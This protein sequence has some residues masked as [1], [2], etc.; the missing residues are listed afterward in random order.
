MSSLP[1]NRS[2]TYSKTKVSE[3]IV[4]CVNQHGIVANAFRSKRL[5]H[6]TNPEM[7]KNHPTR[8]LIQ[9]LAIDC[10]RYGF[11]KETGLSPTRMVR[12]PKF[13]GNPFQSKEP[14]QYFPGHVVQPQFASNAVYNQRLLRAAQNNNQTLSFRKRLRTPRD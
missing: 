2:K 14:S 11:Q 3:I 7:H 1:L 4:K 5:D 6:D 13:A 8:V 9:T 10:T 12:K